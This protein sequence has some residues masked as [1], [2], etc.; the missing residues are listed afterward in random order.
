MPDLVTADTYF[1]TALQIH[2]PTTASSTQGSN[3]LKTRRTNNTT[4]AEAAVRLVSAFASSVINRQR[5]TRDI[6]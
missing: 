2:H 4:P 3:A 6:R 5:G 1:L